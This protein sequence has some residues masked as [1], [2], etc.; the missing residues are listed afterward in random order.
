MGSQQA[1]SIHAAVGVIIAII[2]NTWT[3]RIVPPF[4]WGCIWCARLA[5]LPG[6]AARRAGRNVIS[7]YA[8]EYVRA[9]LPAL[10]VSLFGGSAKAI[11]R[12]AVLG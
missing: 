11:F 3:G 2:A 4:L 5:L 8:R 1:N 12:Y 6:G 10:F 9:V 7:H